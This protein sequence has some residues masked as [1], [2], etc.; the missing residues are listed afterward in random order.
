MSWLELKKECATCHA[1][2][3]EHMVDTERCPLFDQNEL[4]GHFS[5]VDTF[6]P[7]LSPK[8]HPVYLF[9]H[10][11]LRIAIPDPVEELDFEEYME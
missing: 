4:T 1:A 5:K 6:T 10:D 2:S 9:E 8:G 7:M 3:G 11:E